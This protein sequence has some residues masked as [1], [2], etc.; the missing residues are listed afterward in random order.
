MKG[1]AEDVV[2]NFIHDM[3]SMTGEK[4][5]LLGLPRRFYDH[6]H[7]VCGKR[8]VYKLEP[9]GRVYAL[10]LDGVYIFPA[11]FEPVAKPEPWGDRDHR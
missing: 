4:V 6:L 8:T 1:D 9:G 11:E 10:S 5:P 7:R 2:L 3:A